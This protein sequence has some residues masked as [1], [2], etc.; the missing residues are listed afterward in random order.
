MIPMFQAS[1]SIYSKSSLRGEKQQENPVL[2]V[3]FEMKARQLGGD[4][5]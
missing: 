5:W 2:D 3:A 4:V 1:W